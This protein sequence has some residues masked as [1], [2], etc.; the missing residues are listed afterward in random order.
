MKRHEVKR[1]LSGPAMLLIPLMLALTGCGG[2]RG[3]EPATKE[4]EN[5]PVDTTPVTLQLFLQQS[6]SDQDVNQIW[7]EPLKKIYPHITLEIIRPGKDVTIDSLIAA[8]KIPDMI[9]AFNGILPGYYLTDLL[10]DMS[11]LI[12]QHQIDLSRFDPAVMQSIAAVSKEGSIVALP[13]TNQF[14]ALYYNKTLF[15]RFGVP[16]PKDGMTWD[17]AAE[18]AKKLSRSEGGVKFAGM[19][20]ET[21]SRVARP[22]AALKIDGATDKASVNTEAWRKAF[23]LVRTVYTIPNNERPSNTNSLNRFMKEQSVAMLGTVNI[24]AQGLEDAMKQGLDWDM[25]QYPSY[26]EYPNVST[27]VDSHVFSITKTSKHKDQAMLALK[28]FTSDEVQ[29]K[30]TKTTGRLTILNNNDVKQQLGKDMPFLQGKH[31]DAAFKSKI[32]ASPAFS[33]FEFGANSNALTDAMYEY[34]DGK[35]INTTLRDLEQKINTNIA[36]SK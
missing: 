34:I 16:Y 28:V 35:D 8:G 24:L 6:V 4:R 7:V 27:I 17:D 12:K 5:R 9:Y 14:A 19:D 2:E 23:D 11:P 33:R 25:A 21:V 22:L 13:F 30:S 32:I 31:L 20:V 15:N 26:K 3:N 10:M 18:L 29:L 1:I 36:N